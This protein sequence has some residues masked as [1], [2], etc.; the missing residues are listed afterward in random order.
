MMPLMGLS[1]FLAWLGVE[2][3]P[4]HAG[5]G[6]VL[7]GAAIAIPILIGGYTLTTKPSGAKAE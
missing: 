1:A 3:F 2:I 5:P 7:I 6:W 4:E